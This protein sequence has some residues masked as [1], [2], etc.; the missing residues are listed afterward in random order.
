LGGK[1]ESFRAFNESRGVIV[2]QRYKYK[3]HTKIAETSPC[4]SYSI[5]GCQSIRKV[6]AS[7]GSGASFRQAPVIATDQQL[8][9]SAR[10]HN[11]TGYLV[12]WSKSEGGEQKEKKKKEY[13]NWIITVKPGKEWKNQWVT[14]MVSVSSIAGVVSK[15]VGIGKTVA[16]DLDK[17]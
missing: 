4:Q 17:G 1:Y 16:V 9:P 12:R 3:G 6:L 7:V 15:A 11:A 13:Q 10:G 5:V 8:I 2:S 14:I